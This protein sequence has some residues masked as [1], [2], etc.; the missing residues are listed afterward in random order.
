MSASTSVRYRARAETGRSAPHQADQ[1]A[2]AGGSEAAKYPAG[3][4]HG[5]SFVANRDPDI[6]GCRQRG[7]ARV[8]SETINAGQRVRRNKP[9]PPLDD[10][11]V[12]VIMRGLYQID[13][14]FLTALFSNWSSGLP[15]DRYLFIDSEL[16]LY[17][18][19]PFP[20]RP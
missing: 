13:Q 16:G 7:V 20:A 18:K 10:A 6:E 2:V 9:S 11:T 8:K 1:A 4:N 15:R 14:E 17:S 12:V 3:R 19:R 5:G